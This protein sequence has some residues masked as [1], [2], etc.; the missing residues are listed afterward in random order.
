[1]GLLYTQKKKG[2]EHFS[3]ANVF[4]G[5]CD[6]MADVDSGDWRQG[7]FFVSNQPKL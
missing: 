5:Q 6:R 1:M 4:N 3:Y 7:F 2:K